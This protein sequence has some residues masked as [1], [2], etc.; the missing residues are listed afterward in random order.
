MNEKIS[1]LKSYLTENIIEVIAINGTDVAKE[2]VKKT[3]NN[4][5]LET[6]SGFGIDVI[7]GSIPGIGNAISNFRIK[8]QIKNLEVMVIE[9]RK[10]TEEIKK[11]FR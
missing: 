9:L 10:K 4:G 1:E 5:V 3:L 11:K 8:R 2:A 6:I 7:G